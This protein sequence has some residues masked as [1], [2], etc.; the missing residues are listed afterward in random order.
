MNLEQSSGISLDDP[1][2]DRLLSNLQAN[3]LK[4]HGR[5]FAY[6]LFFKFQE[7]RGTLARKW[8]SNFA[9][10]SITSAKRQLTDARDFKCG[11]LGDGGPVFTLS[12]SKYGFEK[13]ELSGSMPGDKSFASGMKASADLLHDKPSSWEAGFQK[14]IDMLV[15]IADDHD[16][17][18]KNETNKLI[19]AVSGFASLVKMQRGNVLKMTTGVGIEHFGYADGISQPMYLS[20]EINGQSQP[21]AWDDETTLGRVLVEEKSE[22][23]GL[24]GSYLVFRKLEQDV[25]GFK[26]AEKNSIGTGMGLPKVVNS[27]G[28]DD[29]ELPGAMI[30]GRFENGT[31]VT[32]KDGAFQPDPHN[33]TNDFSYEDDPGL[34][35]PFH[36]HVRLMNPRKGDPEAGPADLL[37]HRITRRGMPYDDLVP[38]RLNDQEVLAI[39][40][41]MLEDRDKPS[42]G[43]GLLFMCYQSSIGN[44]FEVLQGFWSQG[45]IAPSPVNKGQDSIIMQGTEQSR[46]LPEQW[47]SANQGNPFNFSGFVKMKGGEYFFTPSIPFLKKLG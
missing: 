39:T 33:P 4:F 10:S 28:T 36:A 16:F 47:G 26:V 43:V 9:S 29:D 12:L 2:F 35:C 41:E 11:K 42:D 27:S 13:L 21:R 19:T 24:F 25:K 15:I 3:I 1:K 40:Q 45:N 44:A 38:P 22:E 31:P 37:L 14:E 8:I 5:N 30:V 7:E 32:M 17:N 23:A 34:K 18:A 46:T 6:H 20:D